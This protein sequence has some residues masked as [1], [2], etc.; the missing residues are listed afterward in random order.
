MFHRDE[1]GALMTAVDV[2]LDCIIFDLQESGGVSRYWTNLIC[3]LAASPSGP[4]LHLLINENARTESALKVTELAR[5]NARLTLHPY[6]A[7]L[8][9]RVRE[10]VIPA[11]LAER[12]VFHSSYYRTV[13]DMPNIVTIHDFTYENMVGGW[14]AY[15]QHWQKSQAISRSAAVV[16]VS[17]STRLDF[18]RRFPKYDRAPVDVIHHGI[19]AC[20]SPDHDRARGGPRDFV[21]FVGR[22]DFYKNFWCVTEALKHCHDLRLAVIGPPF[23]AQERGRLDAAIPGRYALCTQVDDARLVELYRRA[24]ALV[25]PSQ[26]EGFG[27]PVLEAMACG[28]P[29]IALDTS[30]IPEVV[31][32]G[33]ILLTEAEPELISSALGR[34]RDESLRAALVDRGIAQAGRFSW[35]EAA[36][37]YSAVYASASRPCAAIAPAM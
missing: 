26:Y 21:L 14:H 18:K 6:K 23:S 28:C 34:I 36:A 29:V 35:T 2:I 17:E 7:R 31:G 13:Q 5:K 24:F 12:A 3:G 15:A 30:S 16:C 25:Y 4:R 32:D 8:L 11:A 19:E 9:D 33:G 22:R 10:P 27:L 37:Q 20:F 1:I